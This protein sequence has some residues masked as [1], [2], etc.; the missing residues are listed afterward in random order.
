MDKK[1]VTW[2]VKG[3]QILPDT[4]MWKGY[5]SVKNGKG[6]KGLDLRA[7]PPLIKPGSEPSPPTQPS[8][9]LRGA[10]LENGSDTKCQEREYIKKLT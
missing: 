9:S 1:F 3:V 8:P 7:E 4:R 10:E 2:Y 5:I 6:G